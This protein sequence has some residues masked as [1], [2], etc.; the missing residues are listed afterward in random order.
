MIPAED[1]F[2]P[3]ISESAYFADRGSLS[4]S[5]AKLLLPPSCPAKFREAQDNPPP[6]RAVFDF[7]TLAHA[8][9]LGKGPELEILDP[10]VHGLKA[11]GTVADVPAMTGMWKKAAAA[12][13]AAG[14]LPVSTDDHNA[15][16]AMRD[17]VMAHPVA[18]PL[19]TDGQPEV[20]AYRTDPET[21]VRLRGRFD[22]LRD[23]GM[24]VDLK[25][26]VTANPAELQRRFWQ[27][28]YYMQAAMY[29]WLLTGKTNEPDPDFVFVTVE[30]TAPYVVTVVR[31]DAEAI[32]EGRRMNR[33]AI[34][35]YAACM[36]TGVWPGYTDG[37]E[38]ISL[39]G[40]ALPKPETLG[41]YLAD[42]YIYETDPLLEEHSA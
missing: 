34:D 19:F 36:E 29:T 18:G 13:R 30:K 12:A 39:P 25:T 3:D 16:S 37:I 9:I 23:D 5:G 33:R 21:G 41:D 2:Y 6:P 20:S 17:A 31:Y 7:G 11:D 38:T 8:L 42:Q 14:K 26:S 28:G 40:W 4:V 1:G 15:A 24:I 10:A 35:L 27:Y 22:W 32:D